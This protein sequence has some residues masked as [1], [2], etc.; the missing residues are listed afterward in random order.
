MSEDAY[1]RAALEGSPVPG[2]VVDVHAHLGEA[3]EFPVSRH[4]DI[5]LYIRE[6][7]RHG[8][9]VA[10]VSALPAC[11]GGLQ[12]GGNAMVLEALERWPARFFG[13]MSANPNY[14]DSL[15]GELERC[16][17]GGCRGVKIHNSV[18]L[19]YDHENYRAVYEFAAERALPILAHTWGADLVTLEPQFA[20][21]PSVRWSLG[22]AG[23]SEPERYVRLAT[24]HENVFLDTCWSQCPRGLIEHF[25]ACGLGGK[26]MF[27][28]DCYFLSLSQ[29]LGR[30]L[31]A[32]LAPEQKAAIL[33]GNAR[34]FLGELCPAGRS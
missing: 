25:V 5:D 3:A 7:D 14:P 30:V 17:N 21:Y 9:D 4:D 15:I 19:P 27:S 13:W 23:A 11:V 28:S 10:C 22:H 2:F 6:M 1:C 31:F 12:E 32:D 34:R 8:V 20:R 26:T 18:G 24:E 16:H 29:Q 33:G